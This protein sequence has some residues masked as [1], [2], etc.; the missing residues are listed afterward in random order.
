MIYRSMSIALSVKQLTRLRCRSPM[1]CVHSS[2]WKPCFTV[3][4]GSFPAGYAVF[5]YLLWFHVHADGMPTDRV[6]TGSESARSVNK[7]GNQEGPDS[8]NDFVSKSWRV[9]FSAV[10]TFSISLVPRGWLGRLERQPR[11]CVV[12]RFRGTSHHAQGE[13]V[14]F[15]MKILTFLIFF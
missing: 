8:R 14:A 1:S 6:K 4:A 10:E 11:A 2:T 3:R 15:Q 13:Y 7:R 5:A 12:H 9:V